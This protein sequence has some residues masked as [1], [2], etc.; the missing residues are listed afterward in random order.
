MII[1]YDLAMLMAFWM[2]EIYNKQDKI[3]YNKD[4]GRAKIVPFKNE[5]RRRLS[6]N[7]GSCEKEYQVQGGERWM[8]ASV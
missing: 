2:K 3:L 5:S 8:A 6:S 7:K 4:D 1:C